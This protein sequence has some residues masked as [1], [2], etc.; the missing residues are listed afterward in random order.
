LPYSIHYIEQLTGIKAHTVRIWEQ[1]YEFIKPNRSKTNIRSYNDEQL[2]KLLNISTLLFAGYKIGNLA[3]M[4]DTQI[5][6]LIT[7]VQQSHTNE[8]VHISATLN[9]LI[10]AALSYDEEL[11]NLL[12]ADAITRYGIE[13]MYQLLLYPLL[14]RVGTLWNIDDM[15]PAQEHFITNLIKQKLFATLDKLNF[16][17]S[18]ELW[19]LFLPETEEHEI[20]LLFSN[21][22]LRFYGIKTIYLGQKMP[23]ENL[24]SLVESKNPDGILYFQVQHVSKET[25]KRYIDTIEK[26]SK[27][28]SK[29]ICTR[30]DT[31]HGVLIPEGTKVISDPR[32]FIHW[33]KSKNNE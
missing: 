1:R 32:A 26:Y 12:Y 14:L 31:F 18:N 28:I 3:K 27:G 5:N 6:S 30:T 11:F 13:T 7:T 33:L 22:M 25:T 21:I 19:L 4:N 24:K 9:S 10:S 17:S 2:K 16:P 8:S 15:I 29:I 20:G 23:L